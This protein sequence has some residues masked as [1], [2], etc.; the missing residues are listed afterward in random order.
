MST[1]LFVAITK[2]SPRPVERVKS[3]KS[4]KTKETL[5][6]NFIVMECDK[7]LMLSWW[8]VSIEKVNAGKK[9][10]ISIDFFIYASEHRKISLFGW[11]TIKGKFIGTNNEYEYIKM[12]L[13]INLNLLSL[14]SLYFYIL[15]FDRGHTWFICRFKG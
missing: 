8:W 6:E 10:L 12:T 2:A 1:C 5:I 9:I 4:T 13:S 14:L 11:S 3:R 7:L 15:F